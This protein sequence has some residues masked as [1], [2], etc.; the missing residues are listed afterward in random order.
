MNVDRK[1]FWLSEERNRSV[2]FLPVLA[3]E[4]N[5]L[6]WPHMVY[7]D[8]RQQAHS[9]QC[10]LLVILEQVK[11]R[12]LLPLPAGSEKTEFADSKSETV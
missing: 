10:D 1:Y 9:L 2:V 7:Q 3:N 4:K 6:D 5:R 8:V 11:G 12:T